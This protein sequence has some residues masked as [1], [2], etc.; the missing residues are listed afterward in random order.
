MRIIKCPY[1]DQEMNLRVLGLGEHKTCFYECSK[2]LSRSPHALNEVMAKN[3]ARMRISK[4]KTA[5]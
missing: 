3:L 4:E 5:V 2:C 1:C